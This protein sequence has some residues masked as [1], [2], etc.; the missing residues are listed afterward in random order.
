MISYGCETIRDCNRGRVKRAQETL[1]EHK[2]KETLFNGT[3][4]RGNKVEI[5]GQNRYGCKDDS[6]TSGRLEEVSQE[7]KYRLMTN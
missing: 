2:L 5:V 1:R 3:Q 6:S 4:I 7:S